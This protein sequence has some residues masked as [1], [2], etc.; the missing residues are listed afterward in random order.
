MAPETASHSGARAPVAAVNGIIDIPVH[1]ITILTQRAGEAVRAH[2]DCDRTGTGEVAAE[3]GARGDSGPGRGSGAAAIFRRIG[4][5]IGTGG[6]ND[7]PRRG[8]ASDV[9]DDACDGCVGGD[10]GCRGADGSGAG[11]EGPRGRG[12]GGDGDNAWVNKDK[13]SFGHHSIREL[14]Q[15][16]WPRGA[17]CLT[18][19]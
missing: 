14:V 11:R 5:E 6:A 18:A 10:C 16:R 4:D 7:G 9:G 19:G 13:T 15:V 2:P 1:D 12:P 8:G 17:R 3:L